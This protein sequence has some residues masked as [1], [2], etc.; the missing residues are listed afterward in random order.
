QHH[1]EPGSVIRQLPPGASDV[2]LGVLLHGDPHDSTVAV[3]LRR[4]DALLFIDGLDHG[5]RPRHLAE[6][7]PLKGGLGRRLLF[8]YGGDGRQQGGKD[9]SAHGISPAGPACYWLSATERVTVSMPAGAGAC[10]RRGGTPSPCPARR[11]SR[12]GSRSP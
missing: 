6:E 11:T 10:R 8:R 5:E 4:D 2:Q 7:I 9:K 3:E 1:V 12:R